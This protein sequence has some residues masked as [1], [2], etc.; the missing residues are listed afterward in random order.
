MNKLF[1]FCILFLASRFSFA[2][3][4]LTAETGIDVRAQT[5]AAAKKE[6]V[7][8]AV[9]GGV[10]QVLS[11]YCDRA[12]I[13]SLIQSADDSVLQNLVAA[14]SIS[15]E[16]QSKTAYGAKISITLDRRAVEK[17]F[18]SN[19]VPNFLSASDESKDR[20]VIAIELPGLSDW[21]DLNR[22]VRED[23]GNYGLSLRTIFGNS[24]TA[25]I[26]TAK[27]RKF[28]SLVAA[29]GWSVSVRDGIVRISR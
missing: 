25:Y 7:D 6:A 17:W 12:I 11:R 8:S 20:S 28:Q 29:D 2:A 9:R 18:E 3:P 21:A 1:V 4:N 26:L 15:N 14:T 10:I 23:G 22:I 13:E 19:N 5:A 27:R 16:K 24:A